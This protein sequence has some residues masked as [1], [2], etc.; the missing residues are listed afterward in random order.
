MKTMTVTEASRHFSEFIS[1]VHY[2]GES[3]I[4]L[5]GGKPVAKVMPAVRVK[6]GRDLASL[7]QH[8]PHLSVKEAEAFGHDIDN[9]RLNLPPVAAKWD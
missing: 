1:R 9:S 6:T 7:W 3:A 2:R 4:L 8:L 5:K